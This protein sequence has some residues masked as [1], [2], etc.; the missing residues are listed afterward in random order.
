M[1][2]IRISCVHRTAAA[3]KQLV[4]ENNVPM[5]SRALWPQCRNVWRLL[6]KVNK[7]GHAVHCRDV[8]PISSAFPA[9]LGFFF[10]IRRYCTFCLLRSSRNGD[11]GHG[12]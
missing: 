9:S 6:P 2:L 8:L 7:A 3:E 10:L 4:D 12:S 5:M 1:Q 11:A